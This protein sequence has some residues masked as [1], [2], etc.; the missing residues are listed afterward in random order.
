MLGLLL[1]IQS[2]YPATRSWNGLYVNITVVVVLSEKVT[3]SFQQHV[4]WYLHLLIL[5][6]DLPF[7]ILAHETI[8]QPLHSIRGMLM[9]LC[10]QAFPGLVIKNMAA[11]PALVNLDGMS[12]EWHDTHPIGSVEKSA[13]QAPALTCSDG[14]RLLI[15]TVV[16]NQAVSLQSS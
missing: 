3:A 14:N 6:T 16:L 8:T 10:R 5:F 15:Q 12:H 4:P 1:A 13:E 2:N 11:G 9:A 7:T